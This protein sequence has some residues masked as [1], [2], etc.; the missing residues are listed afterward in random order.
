M[1]AEEEEF[2]ATI[3]VEFLSDPQ[4]ALSKTRGGFWL[5]RNFNSGNTNFSRVRSQ[6]YFPL[7]IYAPLVYKAN[8]AWKEKTNWSKRKEAETLQLSNQRATFMVA[9]GSTEPW[10][11]ANIFSFISWCCWV[12]ETDESSAAC[13]YTYKKTKLNAL[14]TSLFLLPTRGL[15]RRVKATIFKCII[16][17][18]SIAPY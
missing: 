7:N 14:I 3:G 12:H 16:C 17:I 18:M 13:E 2:A 8:G 1:T 9:F 4:I 15:S 6:N 5:K 11:S 10:N